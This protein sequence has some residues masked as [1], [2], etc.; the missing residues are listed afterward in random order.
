VLA[1]RADDELTRLPAPT[2]GNRDKYAQILDTGCLKLLD[3]KDCGY[4]SFILF[5]CM[6]ALV[7]KRRSNQSAPPAHMRKE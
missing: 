1:Q 5:M 7:S 6:E 4:Y 3:H 2:A